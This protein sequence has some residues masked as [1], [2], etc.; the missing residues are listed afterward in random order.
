[1]NIAIPSNV[2]PNRGRSKT[3]INYTKHKFC[4]SC[5]KYICVP[6]KI[7]TCPDCVTGK[8][9]INN[10]EIQKASKGKE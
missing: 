6:V 7:L 4:L 3:K 10:S 5:L 8:L 9:S 2:W 1:M